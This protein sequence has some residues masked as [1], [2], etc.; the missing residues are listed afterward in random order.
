MICVGTPS[1][2]NG[3]LDLSR[4]RAAC[5]QIGAALGEKDAYHVVVVR[6]TMLPGSMRDVVLPTL[7]VASGKKAG[8]FRPVRHPEFMREGTAVGLPPST[9]DGDREI[10]ERSGDTLL[11]LYSGSTHR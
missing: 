11:Q 6:S 9:E 2:S 5:E 4:V 10:D 8:R 1:Q 3:S 7:E